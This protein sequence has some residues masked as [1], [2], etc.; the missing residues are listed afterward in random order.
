MEGTL[1]TAVRA[2]ITQFQFNP[3]AFIE[4]T[5]LHQNSRNPSVFEQ[6]QCLAEVSV[7]SVVSNKSRKKG[8]L[9]RAVP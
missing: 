5:R 9:A 4:S 1:K 7:K 2:L 3:I 6:C 8:R